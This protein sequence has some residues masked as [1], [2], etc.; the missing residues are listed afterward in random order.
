MP[1]MQGVKS[2]AIVFY[3]DPLTTPQMWHHRLSSGKRYGGFFYVSLDATDSWI[4]EIVNKIR[5]HRPVLALKIFC[6]IF[7]ATLG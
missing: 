4:Q 7:Y 3:A 5:K 6:H 1:Q 2:E